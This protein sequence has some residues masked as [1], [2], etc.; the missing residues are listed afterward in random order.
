MK[1]RTLMVVCVAAGLCGCVEVE[2][3]RTPHS[4]PIPDPVPPPENVQAI[5][6]P[7]GDQGE[8]V[9]RISDDGRPGWWFP[10]VRREGDTL[11]LC[12]ETIAEGSLRDANRSAVEVATT[13]AEIETRRAGFSFDEDA[14]SIEKTWG[15]P[16]PS[17]PGR[18][19]GYAGYAMVAIDLSAL[20]ASG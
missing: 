6:D 8:S 11:V 3:E 7:S 16:L 14:M 18:E 15:W 4:S 19:P 20:S 12:V 2:R 9:E 1:M 10:E 5:S 17:L 13:R